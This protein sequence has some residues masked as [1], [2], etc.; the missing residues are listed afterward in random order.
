MAD[1]IF[2]GQTPLDTLGTTRLPGNL[3]LSLWQ[4][5]AQTYIIR[6]NSEDGSAINLTNYT[7]IAPIRASTTD[8][9]EHEFVCTQTDTNEITLYMSS[10]DCKAIAPGSYIWEFKLQ[11]PNGDIRT[12]LAGDVTVYAEV[13]I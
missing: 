3:D 2:P 9:V 1:I 11:A 4:G 7:A 13:D 6:L 8:P 10:P 12:Y 5:D